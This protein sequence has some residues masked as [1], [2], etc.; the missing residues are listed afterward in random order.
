MTSQL[1]LIIHK[2]SL[3][4]EA[5]LRFLPCVSYILFVFDFLK[6]P[7]KVQ[8]RSRQSFLV[9]LFI[10]LRMGN[11]SE[12]HQYLVCGDFCS[13][14]ETLVWS[15]NLKG[16]LLAQTFNGFHCPLAPGELLWFTRLSVIWP[17][18][19]SA[20]HPSHS[21]SSHSAELLAP[22]SQQV[23]LASLRRTSLP[24]NVLPYPSTCES[25]QTVLPSGLSVH[26]TASLPATRWVSCPFVR[27][28]PLQAPSMQ[29]SPL[30]AEFALFTSI[31][32]CL[33][34]SRHSR[35]CWADLRG[36]KW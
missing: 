8:R 5:I 11:S 24:L 30:G 1:G 15:R 4:T 29:V 19:A 28:L 17:L 13:R 12:N 31:L 32:W 23:S 3:L 25:K 34:C 2:S 22:E 26:C 21:Q 27:P 6:S 7:I 9:L 10:L 16:L 35:V 36:I 20:T 18:L 33:A 14:P